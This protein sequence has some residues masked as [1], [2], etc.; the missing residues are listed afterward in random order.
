MKREVVVEVLEVIRQ[1]I[2]LHRIQ[3]KV[4]TGLMILYDINKILFIESNP[5]PIKYAMYEA[6]LI[7]S[8][9]YRLPLTPPSEENK[10]KIKEIIKK[11]L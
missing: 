8:L 11:Y 6:G 4:C 1:K 3:M 5:I 7:P 10:K 2:L 9:E